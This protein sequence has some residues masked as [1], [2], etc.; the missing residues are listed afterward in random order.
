[1]P[2]GFYTECVT[3]LFARAPSLDEVAAALPHLQRRPARGRPDGGGSP[4]IGAEDLV[5]TIDPARNGRLLIDVV[6]APWPDG[7]GD[8][9]DDPSLFGAWTLGA[10]GRHAFPGNLER[11]RQQAWGLRALADAAA[12][13]TAFVRLRT[14]Y[15]IGA[16]DEAPIEPEG[17]S[18]RTDLDAIRDAALAVLRLP[19]AIASFDPSAEL[20]LSADEIDARRAHAREH[21]M[22]PIDLVSHARLF[23]PDAAHSLVDTVGMARVELPDLEVPFVASLDPNEVVRFVRNVCVYHLGRDE[24]IPSGDTID[25][26]GGRYRAHA[27][28][29][30]LV[31]PPRPVLRLLLEGNA[32][33]EV[34]RRAPRRG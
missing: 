28:D 6:R 27:F 15:V 19:G 20:L 14:S 2:A 30:A 13:H 7:M 3:V 10:F 24:P 32:F 12:D 22:E 11:A 4:W 26:P 29:Q 1:M 34:L 9:K 17:R 16:G 31:A 25:G 23:R 21:A 18:W 33:P 8:P 5:G